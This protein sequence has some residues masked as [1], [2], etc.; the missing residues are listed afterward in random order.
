MNQAQSDVL[1]FHET[2][3]RPIG[4]PSKPDLTVDTQLRWDLIHEEFQELTLALKGEDKLGQT[5]TPEEQV[6]AV[7]DALG[8]IAY[9]VVGA[10]V[11]WGID[12]TGIW[13]AIHES[14]MT[15]TPGN[16]RPDGKVLKGP[17]YK[18]PFLKEALQRSK[19]DFE[20][21]KNDDRE[22]Q[23]WPTP[24]VKTILPIEEIPNDQESR[25]KLLQ[26]A[27]AELAARKVRKAIKSIPK[28]EDFF[29]ELAAKILEDIG[30]IQARDTDPT[31]ANSQ[32]RLEG[33][34]LAR[35]AFLFDCVCERQ[36]EISTILGSRGGRAKTGH[37]ECICGKVYDVIFS[38][39]NG[40]E[41]CE[42]SIQD[43]GGPGANQ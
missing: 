7:A 16:N 24:T 4:N 36:H 5:L 35:G 14:N 23:W 2:M 3:H 21:Q 38:L 13:D 29:P 27:K 9:V 12:L 40:E 30:E 8:D 42:A 31:P 1:E 17:N 43:L 39:H 15:K 34:F 11:T 41:V 6:I 32:Q 33:T 25:S 26:E 20:A 28:N 19:A 10:A 22:D 37:C 18:P